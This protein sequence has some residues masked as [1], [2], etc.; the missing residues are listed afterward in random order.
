VNKDF[1]FKPKGSTEE[2]KIQIPERE[3]RGGGRGWDGKNLKEARVREKKLRS[4]YGKEKGG[5]D[6]VPHR[7][8]GRGEKSR[9]RFSKK[10]GEA[11]QRYE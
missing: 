2:R 11:C 7:F 3:T 10:K 5:K 1:L 9:N 8:P 4:F 6:E